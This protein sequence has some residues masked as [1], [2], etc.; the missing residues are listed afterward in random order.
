MKKII[1][2]LFIVLST[3]LMGYVTIRKSS[4]VNKFLSHEID[5]KHQH[6]RF[7]WKNKNGKNFRNFQNLKTELEKENKEL[8]F[9]MNGGMYNK[10]L[11]PQGLYIENGII[12]S[13]IDTIK[14]GYGNFYLQPNGIFYITKNNKPIIQ[15][16]ELFKYNNEIAYA[17]QSGPMLLVNGQIHNKFNQGSPNIHIRNGVGVL[18]NGNL[19]FVMSKEKV[20]F[21]DFASYF[22]KKGCENALYLDGFVSR[23]YLPSAK[24]KQLDGNFGV[25]LA[26]VK[27]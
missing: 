16:T 9:A 24:W 2:I 19:L 26:E 15:T 25:I 1:L 10:D 18:P 23:T 17:T 11:S 5:L 8:V 20:N 22:K 6:L 4:D 12:K 13:K 3:A 7:Y 27:K 21:Y 14:K